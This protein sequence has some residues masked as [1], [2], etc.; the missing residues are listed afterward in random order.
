MSQWSRVE[1]LQSSN[2]SVDGVCVYCGGDDKVCPSLDTA[3]L[4][5]HGEARLRTPDRQL[6]PPLT[7]DLSPSVPC[8]LH[9]TPLQ[10]HSHPEAG[11]NILFSLFYF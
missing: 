10:S 4:H 8:T 3:L 2:C 1:H 11:L 5:G 7:R 6:T 9:H